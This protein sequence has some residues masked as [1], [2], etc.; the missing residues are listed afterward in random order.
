MRFHSMKVVAALISVAVWAGLFCAARMHAQENAPA[1]EDLR[2]RSAQGKQIFTANCAGCHG[3]DGRGG[4]R[5]PS[6]VSSAKVRRGSDSQLSNIV[7]NGIPGTGMP[8]FR[9]LPPA[10][11]MALVGYLRTLQGSLGNLVNATLPGDP[12][13]G[14]KVFVGKG[15][16]NTCH[17]ISGEGGFLGPDLTAYGA[18]IPAKTIVDAIL[19]PIRVVPPGYRSAVLTTSDGSRLEGIVRNEDNFSVQLQTSD[20]S[21]HFVQKADLQK[22]EYSSKSLMPVNYGDRLSRSELNDLA[23]YLMTANGSHPAA[24]ASKQIRDRK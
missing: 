17:T 6:I 19:K 9:A 16:C 13:N 24:T 18:T 7:S 23:S 14:Q 22:V 21:F 11:V 8:A 2:A 4:E 15:E 1:K 20:G 12:G 3:L 10:Q 5:A